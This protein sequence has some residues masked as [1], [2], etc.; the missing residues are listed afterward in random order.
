[1]VKEMQ[2]RKAELTNKFNSAFRPSITGE[3]R[4]EWLELLSLTEEL[5]RVGK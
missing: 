4:A 3:G 1:M 2:L 5:H